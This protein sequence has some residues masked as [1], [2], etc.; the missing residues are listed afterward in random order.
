MAGPQTLEAEPATSRFLTLACCFTD[1]LVARSQLALWSGRCPLAC[2]TALGWKSCFARLHP[3]TVASSQQ[4]P[5]PVRLQLGQEQS[6]PG[7][8]GQHSQKQQDGPVREGEKQRPG[9][10]IALC[11]GS[12]WRQPTGWLSGPSLDKYMAFC[13]NPF[14]PNGLPSLQEEACT[15]MHI[16]IAVCIPTQAHTHTRVCAHSKCD[17]QGPHR[18][19]IYMHLITDKF[20]KCSWLPKVKPY[21]TWLSS[22]AKE[23]PLPLTQNGERML[24]FEGA[25]S[26]WHPC[27]PGGRDWVGHP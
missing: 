4:G 23:P 10:L 18:H 27:C 9:S 25:G 15:N 3:S 20:K 26:Q 17:S 8:P 6:H 16:H 2:E 11:T 7:V 14:S 22:K 1:N 21:S 5:G 24:R 19:L 12:A 13:L